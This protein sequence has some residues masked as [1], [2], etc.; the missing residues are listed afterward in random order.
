MNSTTACTFPEPFY[1]ISE[2]QNQQSKHD[3]LGIK[4][5]DFAEKKRS[6]NPV[7]KKNIEQYLGQYGNFAYVVSDDVTGELI[8]KFESFS[9]TVRNA[10]DVTLCFGNDE[11]SFRLLDDL[12]FDKVNN[13]SLFVDVLF[14]PVQDYVKF[15][16]DLS[17]E[18]APGPT[19][20]WPQCN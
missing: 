5:E 15:E 3:D 4:V 8:M 6:T 11:Y 13:L 17:L 1:N 16:R 18:D 19:D 7:S 2:I 20:H 9:C 10:T 12:L 14:T